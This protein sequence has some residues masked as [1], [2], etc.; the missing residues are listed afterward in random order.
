MPIFPQHP[1]DEQGC[2]GSGQAEE[3]RG[4]KLGHRNLP[5]VI[6]ANRR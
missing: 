2:A 5:E 6:R 3:K 1:E 4:K